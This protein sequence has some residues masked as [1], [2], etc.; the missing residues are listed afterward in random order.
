VLHFVVPLFLV[1][2]C[3]YAFGRRQE[4]SPATNKAVGD[5]V[6][7]VAL[8][9]LLFQSVAKARPDELAQ[10]SFMI[11]SLAGIAVTFLLAWAWFALVDRTDVRSTAIYSM[12]AT[13]GTSGYMGVPLLISIYGAAAAAPAAIATVLH[14]IP[15]IITMVIVLQVASLRD[16]GGVRLGAIVSSAALTSA[17]NPLL[18]AVVAGAAMAA[19]EIPV[20]TAIDQ[21][22]RFLGGAAGPTALFALGLSLSRFK[23]GA[24]A[25]WSA[26]RRL[27]PLLV[28]KL[29]VL[30][31]VTLLVLSQ[32]GVEQQQEIL[33]KTALLMAA[34]PTGAG[35]YV[36]ASRYQVN[37]E[38]VSFLIVVSLC[39]SIP[40][41]TGLL[42]LMQ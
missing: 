10:W 24:I 38:D 27:G 4:T 30:P 29:L 17:K 40:S 6:F 9:A 12:A 28:L 8:P 31:A 26:V 35:V 16:T 18:L 23:I 37:E 25:P 13:Y 34:L 42:L 5:F 14:N 19:L 33:F 7:Y 32:L 2:L 1:I 41:L 36:F 39:L 3:G 11:A 15:V 22:T 21:F 20:P